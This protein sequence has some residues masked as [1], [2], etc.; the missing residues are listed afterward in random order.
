[1]DEISRKN[2]NRKELQAIKRWIVHWIVAALV[3]CLFVG[4]WQSGVVSKVQK[5]GEGGQ[6]QFE[7]VWGVL[8][9]DL[10]ELGSKV[11]SFLPWA[12]LRRDVFRYLVGAFPFTLSD[13]WAS[14]VRVLFILLLVAPQIWEPLSGLWTAYS[15]FVEKGLDTWSFTQKMDERETNME[16]LMLSD[17]VEFH[18]V[19]V[20]QDADKT[21]DAGRG[22]ETSWSWNQHVTSRTI[23]DCTLE[24]LC[25]GHVGLKQ[26]VL[27]LQKATTC[28][29]PFLFNKNGENNTAVDNANRLIRG[30]VLSRVSKHCG[31]LHLANAAYPLFRVPEITFYFAATFEQLH[32][33][34]K[35]IR[36]FLLTGDSLDAVDALGD[37]ADPPKHGGA[38]W[39]TTRWDTLQLIAR[40]LMTQ[41][42]GK[43]QWLHRVHLPIPEPVRRRTRGSW[44]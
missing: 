25:L 20:T 32:T 43:D 3:L 21:R 36:V 24:D 39:K 37:R 13:I 17:F 34:P 31:A 10:T 1:L 44:S 23:D 12:P 27:N 15:Q 30:R 26:A 35:K 38:D 41:R 9:D 14:V 2:T 16:E 5:R 42:D 33:L 19:T 6:W 29:N 18:L 28:T 8:R 7:D 40:E 4:A 22:A 11:G